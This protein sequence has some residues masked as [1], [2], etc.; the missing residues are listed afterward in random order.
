[1]W[2]GSRGRLLTLQHKLYIYL[3]EKVKYII[4][5]FTT[6]PDLTFSG[7]GDNAD[8]QCVTTV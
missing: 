3:R 8:V 6:H 2:D 7:G 5:Y 4:Y 1:M